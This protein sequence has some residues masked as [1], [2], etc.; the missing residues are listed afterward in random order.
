M[1]PNACT[2]MSF[3]TK[4][5]NGDTTKVLKTCAFR[6]S[7]TKWK[8]KRAAGGSKR[9]NWRPI[10]WARHPMMPHRSTATAKKT[11]CR[12]SSCKIEQ[13]CP[14]GNKPATQASLSAT[15]RPVVPKNFNSSACI[16]AS[17]SVMVL[18]E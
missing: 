6:W 13:N 14:S 8:S 3:E 4:A 5:L 15:I 16:Q 1:Q 10:R 7:K 17:R 12:P 2:G 11:S 9:T 18:G